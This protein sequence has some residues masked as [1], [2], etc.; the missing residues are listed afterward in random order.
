MQ[1][2]RHLP[3]HDLAVE[4]VRHERDVDPAGECVDVG[5]VRDPQLVRRERAEMPVHQI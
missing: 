2:A 5:D 3:A 4:Y 1:R